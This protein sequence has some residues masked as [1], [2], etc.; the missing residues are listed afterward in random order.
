MPIL[1]YELRLI[2]F[3]DILGFRD[4]VVSTVADPTELSRLLRAIDMI[5]DVGGHGYG[6]SRCVSQFSDCIVVSYTLDEESGAFMLLN[7]AALIVIELAGLGYL[8]RGAITVGDL[9]HTEKY[10]VGPAMVR[11]Y[12]M[13]QGAKNPRLLIDPILLDVAKRF[14]AEHHSP[15]EEAEFIRGFMTEDPADGQFYYDY[16]SWDSVVSV[17]LTEA[18]YGEYLTTIGNLIERGLR[19]RRADVRNKYLWLHRRYVAAL[20]VLAA[21]PPETRFQSEN[22]GLCARAAGMPRFAELAAKARS[23]GK[24]LRSS[25]DG[26]PHP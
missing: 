5:N 14:H 21:E 26:T 19:H 16:V 18:W 11:A 17:G 15:E 9:I 25:T 22:P 2:L 10:L 1:S 4:T 13:E 7:N 24:R 20:D 3:L 23:R 12:E 8:L 6:E